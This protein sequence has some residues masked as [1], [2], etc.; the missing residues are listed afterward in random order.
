M[1]AQL[2]PWVECE[3]PTFDKPA[4]DRM[5]DLV[6][7]RPRIDGSPHR[8]HPRPH[9]LRRLRARHHAAPATQANPGI[10]VMGHMDTVHP[11]GTLDG[12][13]LAA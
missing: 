3:S 5:M 9:G 8:A 13:A 1:L 6:V 10:L 7:P 4:V 12:P 2:R 11:I